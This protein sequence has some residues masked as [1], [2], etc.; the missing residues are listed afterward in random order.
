MTPGIDHWM[1]HFMPGHCLFGPDA[2]QEQAQVS[3]GLWLCHRS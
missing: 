2:E 1:L 3:A